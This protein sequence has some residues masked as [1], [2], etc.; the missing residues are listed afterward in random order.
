[1][2]AL[3]RPAIRLIGAALLS[4]VLAA[5]AWELGARLAV[6]LIRGFGLQDSLRFVV[7]KPEAPFFLAAGALL[8]VWRP[9]KAWPLFF[10]LASL[11]IAA[12]AWLD[13]H[14]RAI[15]E[16]GRFSLSPSS[17]LRDCRGGRCVDERINSL[18]FRGPLLPRGHA[19]GTRRVLLFG[20]SYAH[21]SG[22]EEGGTLA[23]AL[24]R[25]GDWEVGSFAVPGLN[26][27]SFCRMAASAVPEYRPDFIVIG[28]SPED[29]VSSDYWERF[30]AY[31]PFLWSLAKRFEGEAAAIEARDR[32]RSRPDF[33]E[34]LGKLL[35]L[36]GL[37]GFK[38][39]IFCYN[40]SNPPLRLA[41][42]RGRLS[43]L[44]APDEWY[45]RPGLA[46]PNDGHPTAQANE[47]FAERI[48]AAL[49][50]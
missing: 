47:L 17:V 11:P 29:A 39:L 2:D 36:A 50:R 46:I 32:S 45:F 1:M 33:N 7:L 48:A 38:P 20:D 19:P 9:S 22:V 26:F 37:H 13:P 31:G 30:D 12:R 8:W 6:A 25:R 10:V 21:G 14:A 18:G 41:Q 35:R 44:H 42:G 49:L 15:R 34:P 24:A 3:R 5:C 16:T 4:W 23:S 40:G 43:L 27:M 28:F